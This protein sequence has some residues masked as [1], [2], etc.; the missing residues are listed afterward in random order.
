MSC[1]NCKPLEQ[2]NAA[3]K[4]KLERAEKALNTIIAGDSERYISVRIARR[5]FEERDK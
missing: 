5:Y 4:D 3:L 2:E 1:D